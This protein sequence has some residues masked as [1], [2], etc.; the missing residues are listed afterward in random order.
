MVWGDR[1]RACLGSRRQLLPHS[2]FLRV[3]E[4]LGCG[5]GIETVVPSAADG[6]LSPGRKHACAFFFSWDGD[7]NPTHS[8]T[9][10]AEHIT[11][12]TV[13]VPERS[14]AHRR[15]RR[16]VTHP[17]THCEAQCT[18]ERTAEHITEHIAPQNAKTLDAW[19]PRNGAS[20]G[21]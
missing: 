7:R 16:R 10:I 19:T 3:A 8:E 6:G 11:E 14:R 1:W 5:E 15:T 13:D 4:S 2:T 21:C 9:H 18:A 12:H 17:R 20:G